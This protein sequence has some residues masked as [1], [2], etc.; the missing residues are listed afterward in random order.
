MTIVFVK[1]TGMADNSRPLTRTFE[2]N[3]DSLE[4]IFAFT[5]EFFVSRGVDTSLRYAVELAIDELFTNM[6]KY[7]PDA[8]EQITIEFQRVKNGL[9]VSMVDYQRPPFDITREAPAVDVDAPAGEREE[10]G[11]GIHLVKEMVDSIDYRYEDAEGRATIT[12]TKE[13]D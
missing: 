3:L 7:N 10:G 12:F 11:L 13:P 4:D 1:N 9:S 6:V 5:E 8:P 2:R